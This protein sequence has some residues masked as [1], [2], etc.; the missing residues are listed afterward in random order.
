VASERGIRSPLL[1]AVLAVLA[2]GA[3]IGLLLDRSLQNALARRTADELDRQAALVF[4]MAAGRTD[5]DPLADAAGAALGAQVTLLA[6]DGRVLGDSEVEA[7]NIAG[8]ENHA[9]RPEIVEARRSGRGVAVRRSRTIG[10]P[11]HYVAVHRG[12]G[13]LA[14]V[15][16]ARR[17]ADI[18]AESEQLRRGL[19][20]AGAFLL[21]AVGGIAALAAAWYRR[22]VRS[23]VD[24]A[25]AV[26]EGRS[27]SRLPVSPGA[28]GR[29]AASF[30]AI[31]DR[32]DGSLQALARE[33]DRRDGVLSGLDEA[34]FA[35]DAGWSVVLANGAAEA[36]VG[37]KVSPGV[38]LDLALAP[39]HVDAIRKSADGDGRAELVFDGPP[40]RIMLA[41]LGPRQPSGDRVL[42]L[43]DVTSV[44]K[45][46]RIRR[47][48]VAN[49]SHELRTPVAV[50][51]ANAENLLD[52]GLE[53]DVAAR[54]MV[55]GIHRHAERLSRVIADLLDIS[56]IEAG[57]FR[58]DA[59]E[60]RLLPMVAP[61]VAGLL[62]IVEARGATLQIDV[63]AT[64]RVVADSKAWDHVLT[65]LLDNATKY[66]A[67][68]GGAVV[69]RA[70][71]R[72]GFVRI[73]I[74]DDGPGIDPK[75]HDRLFERFYRVDKGRSREMGG[76]GLG[77]SI[78]KHLVESMGGAVSYRSAEPRGSVFVVD[79]PR[80]GG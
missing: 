20:A 55:E 31:L 35:I 48:F 5:W 77:L 34:V 43:D 54:A 76:T 80:A 56:R 51:Q 28:L 78:V 18:E 32:L 1:V 62:P 11:L 37:R 22:T 15:R 50:L 39:A 12:D 59:V 75:H 26:A 71:A 13:P 52:G 2:V 67:Q 10:V 45:L 61:V 79:L 7:T 74:Q 69:V 60:H 46:E 8:V 47:D 36:I 29:V 42:V 66:G 70:R 21:A 27:R 23:M 57:Q 41:K 38:P 4:L 9:Q 14:T 6:G 40:M 19:V 17:L 63:P 16:I 53:D 25:G 33:S 49:V 44:R 24:A 64:L 72:N 65:N 73:E 3:A 30:N 58:L 68:P